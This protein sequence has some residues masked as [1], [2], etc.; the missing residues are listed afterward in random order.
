MRKILSLRL[1]WMSLLGWYWKKG[2]MRMSTD[3]FVRIS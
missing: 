3:N 2:L 1:Q